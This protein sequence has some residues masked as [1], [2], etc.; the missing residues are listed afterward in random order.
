[1][2]IKLEAWLSKIYNIQI[3]NYKHKLLKLQ[4]FGFNNKKVIKINSICKNDFCSP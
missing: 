4:D 2:I 3:P 1:M